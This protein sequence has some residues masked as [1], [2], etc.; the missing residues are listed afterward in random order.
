MGSAIQQACH[1][2][3]KGEAVSRLPPDK[4]NSPL[5]ADPDT[6]GGASFE[7]ALAF[8][9]PSQKRSGSGERGR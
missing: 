4:P 5:H 7:G 9:R 2:Y 6:Q 8:S 1:E 3:K